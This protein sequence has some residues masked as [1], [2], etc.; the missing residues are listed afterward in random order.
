MQNRLDKAQ[1]HYREA[2]KTDPEFPIAA[3]NLA[4]I[5]AESGKELDEALRLA[6]IARDKQPE[7]L[8]VAD[9]LGWVQYKRGAYISAINLL[10]QCTSGDPQNSVYK[11]HLA[12]SYYK[13]RKV[14]KA[15]EVLKSAIALDPDLGKRPESKEILK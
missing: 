11:F 2:L 12:L 15:R 5:L 13:D 3:N 14:E 6:K 9:T 7:S 10:E 8:E 1:F 4:W